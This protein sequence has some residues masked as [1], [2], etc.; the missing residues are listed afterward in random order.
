M[1]PLTVSCLPSH[2]CSTWPNR[3][4]CWDLIT[5]VILSN[6]IVLSILRLLSTQIFLLLFSSPQSSQHFSYPYFQPFL[7]CLSHCSYPVSISYSYRLFK[8]SFFAVPI[9]SSSS[10]LLFTRTPKSVKQY[11]SSKYCSLNLF[12]SY[13]IQNCFLTSVLQ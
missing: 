1:P 8:H 4:N 10:S 12:L 5:D 3:L 7:L 6:P 9:F 11:I 2:A 13:Y